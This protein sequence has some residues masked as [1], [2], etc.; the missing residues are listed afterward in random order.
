MVARTREGGQPNGRLL[1]MRPT[2]LAHAAGLANSLFLHGPFDRSHV[3]ADDARAIAI[4]YEME[5]P[6]PL[7]LFLSL[8]CIMDCAPSST[9]IHY[10]KS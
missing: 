5:N 7:S 6:S 4:K 9:A 10:A 2:A 3:N 1:L 8:Q